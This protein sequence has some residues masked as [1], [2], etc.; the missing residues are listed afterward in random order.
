MNDHPHLLNTLQL[1][2]V[3]MLMVLFGWGLYF[4]ISHIHHQ[5][6]TGAIQF[7]YQ[8]NPKCYWFVRPDREAFEMCFDNPP[9]LR[10]N[11]W[12]DDLTYT[13]DTT[14]LKHFIKMRVPAITPA[15]TP[16]P[17]PYQGARP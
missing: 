8:T 10:P 4:G 1:I 11:G 6:H 7:I 12:L 15:P 16:Q 9:P 14:D 3:I 13:D 2:G 5:K 17:G